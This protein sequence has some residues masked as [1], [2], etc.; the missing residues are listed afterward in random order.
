M[1]LVNLH[2]IANRY[3]RGNFTHYTLCTYDVHWYFDALQQSPLQLDNELYVNIHT[4]TH[5]YANFVQTVTNYF[6]QR[7]V[8]EN[9]RSLL[10]ECVT[11]VLCWT[12]GKIMVMDRSSRRQF[13]LQEIWWL[14]SCLANAT[15][16]INSTYSMQ[17]L[18]WI[19]H[20]AFNTLT[21]IYTINDH[22]II[23]VLLKVREIMLVSACVTNLLIIATVCHATATEVKV[24]TR[25]S[26]VQWMRNNYN[27]SRSLYFFFPKANRVGKIAFT[28]SSTIIAK[29][30]FMQVR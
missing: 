19:A 18:L 22:L 9:Y 26:S 3:N 2:L 13:R 29:R 24:N 30:N 1:T 4:H 11:R 14:H 7:R 21:R 23:P 27:W 8:T 5:T 17:L 6:P 12:D 10:I 16:M 15:E 20:M 28:P 25:W